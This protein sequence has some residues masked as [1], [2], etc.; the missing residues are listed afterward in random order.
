MRRLLVTSFA[1]FY[2]IALLVGA[3]G[4]TSTWAARKAEAVMAKAA[5]PAIQA[6]KDYAKRHPNR[7]IL[8]SQFVVAPPVLESGVTLVSTALSFHPSLTV[9]LRLDGAPVPS[10]APPARS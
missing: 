6:E 10:R 3:L 2:T 4:R 7:R 9:V 1:A 8:Q 5:G